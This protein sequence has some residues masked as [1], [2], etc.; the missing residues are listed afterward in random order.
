M[1]VDLNN[2]VQ[3]ELHHTVVANNGTHGNVCGYIYS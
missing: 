1:Y 2:K 3:L